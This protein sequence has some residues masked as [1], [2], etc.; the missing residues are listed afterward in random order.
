MA[1]RSDPIEQGTL[2]FTIE[3]R[4][5]RE[6]GE[7]IVKQPEVALLELVKNAY[8]SDAKTCVLVHDY[9]NS[10]SVSDDGQGMTIKEFKNGWMRIGTS[11][12]EGSRIS[13]QFGRVITGEKGIGRF[14]V[15]YLGKGLRLESVAKDEERGFLT[16]L[17][18]N[19]DWPKF[20]QNEDL[21]KVS[22]PYTLHRAESG[23][24]PG[25][26]LRISKLRPSA[27][28]INLYEV[29]T[30]SMGVVTPYHALL[31]NSELQWPRRLRHSKAQDPGFALQ[32]QPAYD[33][34]QEGDIA[35]AVLDGFAFR[36]VVDLQDGSLSLKVFRK[37]KK[38]P[39]MRIIDKYDNSVG[40]IYADIRFFPQ[41]KGTFTDLPVD[42]R[43]AKTWVKE[44]SGVAVFDRMFRVLPYG[45]SE[46]DW[47][48]LAADTAKRHRK[49]RSNIAQKH[50]PMD[51][52]TE[53]S[54]ETNYM[55]RL[56]YPQQL[57]GVVQV[58]GRS[59]ER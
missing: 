59:E 48:L 13:R 45:T 22:I 12:K 41:R 6:I 57:V 30:S 16:V 37:G 42:G 40:W 14:A 4:F 31:R 58:E 35:Q 39:V 55:L 46:D 2:S 56:P 21:G 3:S 28:S 32:I 27:E 50:F 44:N 11:S 26:V 38:A 18:A 33:G 49:Q 36:A 17:E 23:R 7:R 1:N 20:D 24:S 15:R 51:A 25:T 5:I 8:D 47:L 52:S 19:F 29:R 10:I 43:R 54:T 34:D 53:A 9:P